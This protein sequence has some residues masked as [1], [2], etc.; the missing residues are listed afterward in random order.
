MRTEDM[1]SIL[2]VASSGEIV[3]KAMQKLTYAIG[4]E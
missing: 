4:T 1:Q 3:K 2:S